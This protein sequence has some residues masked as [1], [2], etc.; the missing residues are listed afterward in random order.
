MTS[1]TYE[2]KDM[3][4]LIGQTFNNLKLL[5]VYEKVKGLPRTGK[6]L[7]VCGT[8]KAIRIGRVVTGDT[9]ACGCNAGKALTASVK[10]HGMAKTREFHIWNNMLYRCNSPSSKDYPKYGGVGVKVCPEWSLF[11]NFLSDMGLAPSKEHSLDRI[12]TFGNYEPENC[13]WADRETQMNNRR[14]TKKYEFN[15]VMYSRS[16]LS[17][18]WGVKESRVYNLSRKMDSAHEIFKNLRGCDALGG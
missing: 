7:C 11:E 1:R 2:L 13:R 14:T 8:E 4:N 3:S 10:T 12:D 16:Q 18:L 5:S 6:F 15:G 9:K 17:R